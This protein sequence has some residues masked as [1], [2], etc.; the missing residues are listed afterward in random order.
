MSLPKLSQ[1]STYEEYDVGH[2]LTL[3]TLPKQSS[4]T[5]KFRQLQ[6]QDTILRLGYRDFRWLQLV[7]PTKDCL[8]HAL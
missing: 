2:I 3:I 4:A 1:Y 8:L 5:P 7:D 6:G